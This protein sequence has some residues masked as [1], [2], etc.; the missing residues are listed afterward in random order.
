MGYLATLRTL[1]GYL[2]VI[3]LQSDIWVRATESPSIR[4]SP[5]LEVNEIAAVAPALMC[6][7][8]SI[9]GAVINPW[10]VNCL[11]FVPAVEDFLSGRIRCPS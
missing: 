8:A 9:A 11:C 3:A 7:I 10:P 5:A 6:P 4:Q 2:P 1:P